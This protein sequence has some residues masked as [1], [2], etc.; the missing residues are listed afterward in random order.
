M[1]RD[2]LDAAANNPWGFPQRDADDPRPRTYGSPTQSTS[3]PRRSLSADGLPE[4]FYLAPPHRPAARAASR[5]AS[6]TAL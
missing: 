5:E 6:R 3:W 1:V 2:V 4:A